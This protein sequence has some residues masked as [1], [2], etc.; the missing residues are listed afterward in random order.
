LT[1]DK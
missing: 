1:T